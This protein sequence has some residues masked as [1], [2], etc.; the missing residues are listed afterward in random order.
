MIC[1]HKTCNNEFNPKT[2][3]MK[4]CSDECCR[5]ATN[6]KIKEKYYAKKERLSGKVRICIN[7]TCDVE[8]SKYNESDICQKCITEEKERERLSLLSMLNDLI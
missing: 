3:N 6:L 1:A 8:L 2:H 4:Y 5:E 7:K